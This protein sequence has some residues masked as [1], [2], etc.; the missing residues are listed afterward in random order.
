MATGKANLVVDLGNSETR[1]LTIFGKME[2]GTM[3]CDL[4]SLDNHFAPLDDDYI[5]TSEYDH[6]NSRVFMQKHTRLCVGDLCRKEFGGSNDFRPS[7]VEKKYESEVSEMSMRNA[8]LQGYLD[9]SNMIKEPVEDLDIE[10]DVVVLLPPAD[11]EE[12]S[13]KLSRMIKGIDEIEFTMPRVTKEIKVK[14]VRILAEGFCAYIAVMCGLDRKVRT[15]YQHMAKQTTLIIDIGAGTTDFII[16]ENGKPIKA[17]RYSTP[18]GG[19]NVH[20][21]VKGKLSSKGF[22]MPEDVVK[23]ASEKGYIM[24]GSKRVSLKKEISDAKNAV[25]RMIVSNIRDYFEST[26]FAIRRIQN[27]VV[28]GGGAIDGIEDVRPLGEYTEEYMKRLSPNIELVELPN[29]VINGK[30]E[31]ISPRILNVLG[32]GIAS[33]RD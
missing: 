26:G 12:G 1:V 14:E 16:I 27:M 3:R 19:N 2:N 24:D 5:I 33:Y 23:E 9:I 20:Q 29:V 17:S 31:K 15:E 25:A 32:A 4:H 11:V 28:C 8:F 18:I 13:E 21:R 22:D 10:W 6:T 30:E 7:A